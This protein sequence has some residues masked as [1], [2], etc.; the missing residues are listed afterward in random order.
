MAVVLTIL[1]ILGIILLCIIGLLLLII[2][3]VLLVPVRY[4]AEGSYN[5]EDIQAHLKIRWLFIKVLGDFTKADGL[6]I[7]AKAAFVTVYEMDGKKAAEQD[8]LITEEGN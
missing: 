1:K 5:E 7:K 4:R 2:A 8:H 6:H 3:L